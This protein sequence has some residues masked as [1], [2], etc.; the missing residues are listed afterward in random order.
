MNGL[1]EEE[2]DRVLSA[3]R[4]LELA[5]KACFL[6]DR[7]NPEEQAKLLKIVLSNCAIEDTSLYPAYRKPFDL[8]LKAAQ[9]KKWWAWGDSNSRPPV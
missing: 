3:T 7:Q 2:E 1:Q 8:I 9:T 6:Y 5:N 4:I